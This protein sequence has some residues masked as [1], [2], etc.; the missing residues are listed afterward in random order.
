LHLF[1]G[2]IA[3]DLAAVK[4]KAVAQDL[5]AWRGSSEATDFAD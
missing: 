1:A 3:N 5:D 2:R 4:A